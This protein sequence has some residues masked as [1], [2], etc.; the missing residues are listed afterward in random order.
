VLKTIAISSNKKLGGCAA[1]YRSG[2]TSVYGTCPDSCPLKPVHGEGSSR[3]DIEYLKAVVDAVPRGGVSWTY[4]HFTDGDNLDLLPPVQ[5]NR[6]VINVSAD[7]YD[8][9]VNAYLDGFPT[10][11]AVPASHDAKVD[12]IEADY[13][14]KVRFVRCP[15]EYNDKVT[16]RNCGSGIP[17]CARGDR[18][19]V[20]KFTAHG[21]QAKKVGS[22]E[23]GGCYGSGGP[24]AI[25]WKNTMK[26]ASTTNR[27]DA[28]ILTDWVQ[29]LPHGT[30]LRHH[31]VGDLGLQV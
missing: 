18:N 26:A 20:I 9:A 28:Q 23:A 16:C 24:V 31:V 8:D 10:V 6:T 5:P 12:I 25:Q 19:Y 17:L 13:R 11:V 7:S 2:S 29:T 22:E 3:I 27:S 21:T 15:A 1:T 4:T 30:F 14:E